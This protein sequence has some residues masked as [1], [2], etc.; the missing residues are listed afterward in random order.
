MHA[1]GWTRQ[2]ALDYM[3]ENT[4]ATEQNI[5]AEVDATLLGRDRLWPTK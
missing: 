2:Q 5:V 4:A 1:L 3:R